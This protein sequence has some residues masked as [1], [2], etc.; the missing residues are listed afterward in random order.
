MRLIRVIVLVLAALVAAAC[1]ADDPVLGGPPTGEALYPD[2]VPDPP[3][4]L[5]TRTESDGRQL[6]LFTSTLTNVGAG[7]FL[8]SGVRSDDDWTV[9]QSIPYSESGSLEVSVEPRM[10]WGGDGHGH[11]HVARVA[12]NW[13]QALDDSAE[14]IEDFEILY[15]AK[16]GFCFFDSHHNLEFGAAKPGYDSSGCGDEDSKIF[17]VGLSRGWSDE[18]DFTLPGQEIEVTGLP[19]GMYRLWSEADPEGWFR[20]SS[21]DNNLTWVNFELSTSEEDGGRR[22]LV[23]AVGPQSSDF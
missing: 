9:E 11:W 23:V 7:D 20:E 6:V 4:S 22:A 19:D 13:L 14:P 18:Y 8:L 21:K 3:T 1:A 17:N 5:R 15:D 12:V 10:V 2:L 16:V